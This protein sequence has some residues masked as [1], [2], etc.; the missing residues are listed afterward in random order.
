MS[1][2]VTLLAL[3]EDIDPAANAIEKL[4]DLGV[5]DDDMNIISGVPIPGR[6]LGRPGA[7]TYVSRIALTGAILGML[8]GLSLIYG[9]PFL[10]PL[11][12][13]GQAV[14]P[15]PIGWII[16][17]EMTMLGLMV[18]A[19]L[20]LFVD[21]GFPSYTPKEYVPEISNGKIAIL[22]K[23]EGKDKKKFVDTLTK[24]GAES[25]K[26]AEARQL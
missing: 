11:H 21:S 16:T 10:Y 5:G 23:C 25:V 6:V 24:L 15:V 26:P 1:D 3:F 4:H 22:F 2:S 9:I 8:F 12:V 19:F 18:F 17:F 14:Y 20:G 7:I 13:G